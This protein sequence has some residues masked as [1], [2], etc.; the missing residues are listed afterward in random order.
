MFDGVPTRNAP[1]GPVRAMSP[2]EARRQLVLSAAMMLLIALLSVVFT[3][4]ARSPL[5]SRDAGEARK[6][7]HGA[8]VVESLPARPKVVILADEF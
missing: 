5:W 6:S 7:A 3:L 1:R 2:R 8:T 4:A